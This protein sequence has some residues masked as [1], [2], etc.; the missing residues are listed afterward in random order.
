MKYIIATIIA[1]N[2]YLLC[3]AFVL[4]D[5]T[6]FIHLGECRPIE[7]YFT[8]LFLLVFISISNIVVYLRK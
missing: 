2:A 4:W 7:R 8:L 3:V 6:W 5:F 1:L